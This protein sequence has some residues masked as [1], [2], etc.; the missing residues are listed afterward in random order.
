MPLFAVERDLSQVPPE[1]FRTDVKGLVAAC[2]R[3][4]GRGKRVRYISSAVFPSEARGL[5]LFGA[6]DPEWIREVNEAM[7]LP[8]TRIFAVLDLT[9]PGVRRDVSCGRRPQS[10]TGDPPRLGEGDGA[11]AFGSAARV[12][13]EIARWSDEGRQL[14][15]VLAGWLGEAGRIQGEA[16][17]LEGERVI[18][19][20]AVRR[21]EEEN[22]ALRGQRDDLLEALQTLAGQMTRAADEILSRFGDR[23]EAPGD[24]APR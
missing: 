19:A 9:P 2:H 24:L 22:R 21:L 13:T 23:R 18:A 16:A 12:S 7:R 10:G 17:A 14:V 6:E 5:C 15:Q 4:Q 8:Y 11:A 20:D 3:L 1:R